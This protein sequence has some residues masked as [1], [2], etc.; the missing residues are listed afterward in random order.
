MKKQLA[1]KR[2]IRLNGRL[3]ILLALVVSIC[4]GGSGLWIISP[5]SS[6][7]TNVVSLSQQS[8][9]PCS[10]DIT[11]P[12]P[13]NKP[14]RFNSTSSG[15]NIKY[16]WDFGDD[17]VTEFS[18]SPT[19][20]HTY[21]KP[22]RYPVI[23]TITDGTQTKNCATTQ[24]IHRPLQATRPTSSSTIIIDKVRG[25][26]W[27]VNPDTNTVA[28]VSTSSLTKAFEVGVGVH[29]RTLAQA[30][31]GNIWVVNQDSASISILNPDTG[32]L[33]STI[34]LS[35]GTQPYGI[36][37]SP[38]KTA[39]FVTLQATGQLLK[40]NPTTGSI[41]SSLNFSPDSTG[42]VPQVRGVA[43]S[44]DSLRVLVTR[45]ISPVSVG[46][47]FEVDPRSMKTVRTFTLA[48]DP[49][50]DS[51]NTGR[52]VPNYVSSI[53]ISPDGV[54]AWIPSKKDNTVRGLIR[55]G[56]PLNFENTVRTIASQIDLTTNKEDLSGRVDFENQD[57]AVAAQ[58][59]P[60]GDLV[61]VAV[62]GNNKVQ[63]MNAYNGIEVSGVTT[64]RA[65]QGLALSDDGK[66]FVQNFLS[67]S[68]SV[69]DVKS[70]LEGKDDIAEFISEI[71]TVQ[72]ETLAENVLRGKQIF[73][74]AS[75][76]RMSRDSYISCASCHLDGGQDG[77]VW[78]FTD[79]GEGLRN[80]IDLRGRSGTGHG[81]LHWSANFDEV[82]D[83]EN[84]I[85]GAFNGTGFLS[86]EH[87][88]M[89]SNP[90]GAPK[91]GKSAEL[92]DLSAYVQSLNKVNRSPYRNKDGSLT[93]GGQAGKVL[94]AQLNCASCHTGSN[95]TN[96]SLTNPKTHD[97][98]TIK[99]S[100][101]KGSNQTLKGLDTPTLKGIWETAPYFHDGS[102]PTLWDVINADTQGK[103]GATRTL[104]NEQ[105][106]QLIEYLYQ[107]DELEAGTATGSVDVELK[108]H[109]NLISLP[110]QPNK[111]DV[112]TVLSSIA[113]AYSVVYAYNSIERNYQA[114]SPSS[115]N[116]SLSNLE[117]GRGYWIYMN[118]AAVLRINGN[119]VPNSFTLN[120][121]WNLVGYSSLKAQP[122][123]DALA[124]INGKY[125]V[126][127]GFEATSQ[128]YRGYIAGGNNNGPNAL[129]TLEP[130]RGYWI[131]TNTVP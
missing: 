3:Y 8:F 46:E 43:I 113:G 15:S 81:P 65:P 14:V 119:V 50:P 19:A 58:L 59:S 34:S 53:T 52:G 73:Y 48:L 91:A 63:V 125:S 114:Y 104:S 39:A 66:L 32:K 5:S 92:D 82:Q 111:A 102:A 101:G 45:F 123:A 27:A 100:S 49:G 21:M 71:R 54:R 77:R 78:D 44:H 12:A 126:V 51:T 75:D 18:T 64:G 20:L 76:P 55:D 61:F 112:G 17:T 56:L 23:L 131:Y 26:A 109:W 128:S 30:P 16:R 2:F 80:T 22:D 1:V 28:A 41:V 40:L 87:F 103:H 68:I 130:G 117:T 4:V 25:Y 124:S 96:S 127:Y 97:V 70:L 86:D 31:N 106:S 93:S 122:V 6:A 35:P 115:T 121:E 60:I 105:K 120:K 116:N 24:I 42:V 89:T 9:G 107:I 85:R 69:F 79:R 47:I 13:V 62:Q 10:I 83:F 37:F 84:D 90:L 129:T 74:D 94:F 72:T 108:P 11:S 67:R 57:M 38:D 110:V 29:P 36:A 88:T 33:S 98:G 118:K 95:F 7:H 99:P